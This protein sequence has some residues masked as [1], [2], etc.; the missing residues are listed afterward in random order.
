MPDYGVIP[1]IRVTDMPRALA[2]YES[3]LGFKVRRGG[4]AAE[5]CSLD[6]NGASIMLETA[7]GFY[8]PAYNEAIRQRMG[9][10]SAIALNVEAEDLEPLLMRVA[11][12]GAKI[13]DPLADREWGQSEFTV[14]DP[15]GN[16][17]T[18][19]RVKK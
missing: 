12:A 3:V 19:W 11:E 18:F 15:E 6:R 17:L 16:W 8:S 5:H 9:T 10:P 13:I 1:S 14:E 2:F 4:P 7:A